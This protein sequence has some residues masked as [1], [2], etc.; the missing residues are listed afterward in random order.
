M[1]LPRGCARYCGHPVSNIELAIG[2]HQNPADSTPGL[3]SLYSPWYAYS[4]G[5]AG[6]N[7]HCRLI[8][9]IHHIL[10]RVVNFIFS[11]FPRKRE[12]RIRIEGDVFCHKDV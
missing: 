9:E 6:K 7:E 1:H 12:S 3:P 2:A 8:Y 5:Q 11:S 10:G 4:N